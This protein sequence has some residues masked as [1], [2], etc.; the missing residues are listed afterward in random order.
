MPN[1]SL[2]GG[3]SIARQSCGGNYIPRPTRRRRSRVNRSST[4]PKVARR[5]DV[6]MAGVKRKVLIVSVARG[7]AGKKADL[8]VCWGPQPTIR[9]SVEEPST[10]SETDEQHRVAA[11]PTAAGPG[12]MWIAV[13]FATGVGLGGGVL[14]SFAQT[15]LAD[16]WSALANSGSTWVTLALLV[17]LSAAGR[18]RVG[19]VA[20]FVTLAWMVVGYYATS[21]LRGF[22]V[23]T[24]AILIWTA[25]AAVAGP[26]FGA[27]GALVRDQRRRL[28]AASVGITGSVWLMEGIRFLSLATDAHSNSGPGAT[29]GWCYILVGLGLTLVLGRSMRDRCIAVLTLFVGTGAT[30]G[31]SA[32][33]DAAF[34]WR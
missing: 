14:T 23:G 19:A 7:G 1:L 29:A 2:P 3:R 4:D 11:H 22:P 16:G 25:V 15:V 27:A 28:R 21:Q 13:A 17:G 18:W 20:G 9:P 26:V 6:P 5:G 24:D 32:L 12:R 34:L 30:L 10:V 33:I 8:S 31:A